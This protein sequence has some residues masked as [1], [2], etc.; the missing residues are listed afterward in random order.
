M[1]DGKMNRKTIYI[2]GPIRGMP[3]NNYNAFKAAHQR[4]TEQGWH[5][6]DPFDITDVF[7]TPADV[8]SNPRLLRAVMDAELAM[9]PRLDAIYLL[10]GWERSKGAKKE[11]EVAL[12]WGLMVMVEGAGE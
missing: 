6:V 5:V 8:Q 12:E 7:G 4:L 1:E 10:R 11:L 9:I 2:A 3:G